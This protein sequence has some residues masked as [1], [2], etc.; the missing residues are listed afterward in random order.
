MHTSPGQSKIRQF[1]AAAAIPLFCTQPYKSIC[2][3]DV[4]KASTT[5]EER[6]EK[7]GDRLRDRALVTL[8]GE[9]GRKKMVEED[10]D[11]LKPAALKR[12]AFKRYYARIFELLNE[13]LAQNDF[14]LDVETLRQDMVV[15]VTS[16]AHASLADELAIISQVQ[17]LLPND[18]FFEGQ[19]SADF[20]K[21]QKECGKDGMDDNAFADTLNPEKPNE[22]KVV[23]ICPGAVVAAVEFV[24]EQRLDSREVVT[25]LAMTVGHEF[26]HHI[27]S[28]IFPEAFS[29]MK[30]CFDLRFRG[31]F[32]KEIEK[33]MAEITADTFGL[34]V[35]AQRLAYVDLESRETL[36]EGALED[37]CGN[38]DDH[39]HPTGY[40]RIAITAF[41]SKALRSVLQCGEPSY[42][43]ACPMP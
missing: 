41:S 18:I 29:D 10:L 2:N 5:R 28:E 12:R 1:F 36:L 24:K 33:Y 37:M 3:V 19:Q 16:R 7:I 26:G 27:D 38:P 39:V 30:A 14:S 9:L 11:R 4:R 8:A 43:L 23:M 21:L 20:R 42:P 25:A 22:Q 13:Y 32:E 40:Y 31:L 34:Q 35:L 6:I 17:M 15:A